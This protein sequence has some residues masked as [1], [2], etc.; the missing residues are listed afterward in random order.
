MHVLF[1]IL[2]LSKYYVVSCFLIMYVVCIYFYSLYFAT[3]AWLCRTNVAPF[4]VTH[5][6]RI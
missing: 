3:L 5:T 4:T 6:Y 1:L 2:Y